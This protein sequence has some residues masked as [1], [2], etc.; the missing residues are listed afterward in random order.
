MAKATNPY[1]DG[2]ATDR[3]LQALRFHFGLASERPEPFDPPPPEPFA[4][5]RT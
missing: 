2:R 5:S 4:I 3:I 1:G